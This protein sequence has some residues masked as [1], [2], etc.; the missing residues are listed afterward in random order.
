MKQRNIRMIETNG[1]TLKVI[2]EGAARYCFC[3][4]AFR[5]ADTCGETRSTTWSPPA[6]RLPFPINAAR[7]QRQTGR[8][9][10]Y[11]TVTLSADAVGIADAL[12]HETFTLVTHDWGAIVGWYIA[13]LYPNGSTRCSR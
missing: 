6:I 5:N 2:V 1:I 10:A 4:T 7:R 9:Q 8:S 13:S 11:D 3:C 12:G